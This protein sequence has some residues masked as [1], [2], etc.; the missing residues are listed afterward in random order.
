MGIPPQ[1]FV[2]GDAGGN[3]GWTIAGQIPVKTAHNAMVP[4]DWS[5]E[6]GWIG[7]LHP[8]DYPRVIN[9][10]NDRIWTANSR[11]ADGEALAA[12]DLGGARNRLGDARAQLG[13]VVF[14]NY[15][16]SRHH[17]SPLSFSA[18]TSPAT[19]STIIPFPRSAGG[20]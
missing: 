16:Y 2:V 6:H 14:S 19:S 13:A 4:V 18:A 10:A 3:I 1:N 5:T 20:A 8:A 7:W 17:T 9:P 12:T 15:E 11:V